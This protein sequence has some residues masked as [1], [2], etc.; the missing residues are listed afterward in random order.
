[1]YASTQNLYPSNEDISIMREKNL[2]LSNHFSW[3]RAISR[4]YDTH[5]FKDIDDTCSTTIPELQVTLEHG[6]RAFPTRSYEL[7]RLFYNLRIF[8]TPSLPS[9]V[10]ARSFPVSFF[11][12]DDRS[13]V[14]IFEESWIDRELNMAHD[15]LDLVCLDEDSLKSSLCHRSS[16]EIEHVTPSE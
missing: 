1:M 11:S 4:S 3:L 16:R 10:H 8:I 7:D 14:E 9:C 5:F 12:L 6:S 13:I 2:E 15:S